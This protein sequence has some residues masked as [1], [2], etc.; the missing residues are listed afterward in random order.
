MDPC[1]FVHCGPDSRCELVKSASSVTEMD[2]MEARCVCVAGF[3]ESWDQ[4]G[5]CV[6]GGFAG[7]DTAD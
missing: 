3:S 7:S 5:S 1:E 4:P 6:K 2:A